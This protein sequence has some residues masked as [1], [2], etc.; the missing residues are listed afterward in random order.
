MIVFAVI[1]SLVLLYMNRDKIRG[2]SLLIALIVLFCVGVIWDQLSV[3][4]GIW[5][6]SEQ[7]VIGYFLGMPVEEYLFM[8]FVP[9]LVITV[10]LQIGR[11]FE[12]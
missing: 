4:L 9:L 5:S 8:I 7:E 3:R 6:F 1:P 11:I 2:K 10:Y 12:K